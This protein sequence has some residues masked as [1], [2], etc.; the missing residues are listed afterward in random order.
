MAPDAKLDAIKSIVKSARKTY[1]NSKVKIN[2]CK[3]NTCSGM[4]EICY[5]DDKSKLAAIKSV[6]NSIRT[7]AIQIA[8]SNDAIVIAREVEKLVAINP[9]L[10]NI[11]ESADLGGII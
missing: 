9:T 6:I 3:I 5:L 7:E 8:A 4:Q 2:A 11:G 1:G 10:C